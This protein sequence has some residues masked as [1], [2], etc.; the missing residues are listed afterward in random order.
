MVTD[1]T[2][3]IEDFYLRSL[4]PEDISEDYLSWFEDEK[5]KMFIE[6]ARQKNNMNDLISYVQEKNDAPN[7]LL[8]GIFNKNNGCHIGNIK[9]EPINLQCKTAEMGILIG[10]KKFRGQGIAQYV[11]KESAYWLNETYGI[12]NITLGVKSE[13]EN[14]ISAYKKIGFEVAE[15]IDIKNESSIIRMILKADH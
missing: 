13:N 4:K 2:I 1:K 5:A 11:I 8:L 15:I 14:A 6:Y 12:K 7:A 9:Y 10:E 3:L